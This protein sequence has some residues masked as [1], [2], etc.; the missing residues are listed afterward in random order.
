MAWRGLHLTQAARLSFLNG[1]LVVARE[2]GEVRTPIEDLGWLVIDTPQVTLS[3]VVIAACMEAGVAIVTTDARHH[4]S[5][6][7]LPFHR[8]HRQAA[9]ASLQIGAGA[10]LKKRM[11]QR[12]VRA[13]IGNRWAVLRACRGTAP[14][15]L[16]M[17]ELV[18]SG[19][20]E[21]VEAR[22]A[23][24]YWSALWPAFRRGDGADL[25]NALLDYGYAVVRAAVARG[26]VAAGLLPCIG[27]HHEG[28]ANAFNLA[29]DM[30]EPFRPVV[31]RAVH[32]LAEGGQRRIGDMTVNDRRALAALP[33]A[34]VRLEQETMTVLAATEIVAAA[35]V[36][37]LES[38][39]AAPLRLPALS[40]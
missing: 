17:A 26:L 40:E 35:L 4:P 29:D 20:P 36:R 14:P 12:I 34:D 25:R 22:A 7:M 6:M 11:W 23:R 37:A 27:L 9:V 3:G 31:E 21:N 24:A 13:K 8:H 5:G 32:A 10:P 15:L 33:R 38:G 28:A 16:E 30:I 1:Q 19:D 2:Q 18:G 39:S